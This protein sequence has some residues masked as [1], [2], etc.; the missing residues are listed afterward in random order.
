MCYEYWWDNADEDWSE[1]DDDEQSDFEEND[2]SASLTDVTDLQ[3]VPKSIRGSV[4]N[5]TSADDDNMT[6]PLEGLFDTPPTGAGSGGDAGAGGAAAGAGGDSAGAGA[7]A[8]AAGAGSA[9]M[10]L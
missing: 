10:E 2:E 3:D 5:V 8:G 9:K 1:V 4:A 6:D 7:N